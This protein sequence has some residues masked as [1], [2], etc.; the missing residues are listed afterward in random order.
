M[1]RTV[2][3][4]TRRHLRRHEPERLYLMTVVVRV[5]ADES[6]SRQDVERFLREALVLGVDH[7]RHGTGPT[8][9]SLV[10][11]LVPVISLEGDR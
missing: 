11:V 8:P 1:A 3:F 10:E 2:N 9:K 6:V 7:Q 4:L 5:H